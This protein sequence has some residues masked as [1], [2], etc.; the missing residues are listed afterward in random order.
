MKRFQLIFP[1]F[2]AVIGIGSAYAFQ[3]KTSSTDDVYTWRKA[4]GTIVFAAS[5]AVAARRCTPGTS[6]TCL[7]GTRPGTPEITIEGIFH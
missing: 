1:V 7:I 2:A 4:D 5:I 6:D 3:P